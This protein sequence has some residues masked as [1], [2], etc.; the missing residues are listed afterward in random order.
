M[1]RD[2]GDSSGERG[3]DQQSSRLSTDYAANSDGNSSYRDAIASRPDTASAHLP[4]AESVIAG[5]ENEN[6]SGKQRLASSEPMGTRMSSD[7]R[8]VDYPGG[9]G[10]GVFGDSIHTKSGGRDIVSTKQ[11]DGSTKTLEKNGIGTE[12]KRLETDNMKTESIYQNNRITEDAVTDKKTGK[13][14]RQLNLQDKNWKEPGVPIDPGRT[15]SRDGHIY[16]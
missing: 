12:I 13:T 6:T 15:R 16:I 7:G 9:D 5:L 14:E 11:P 1:A 4:P 2:A 10:Y 3:L 8:R